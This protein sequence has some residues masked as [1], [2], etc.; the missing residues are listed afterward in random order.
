MRFALPYLLFCASFASA[1]APP[2]AHPD[3]LNQIAPALEQYVAKGELAGAV[4]V[5]GRSTGTLATVVVGNRTLDP[6]TP[7]TADTVF[8]IAS[9]TKP[10][11]ALAVMMLVENG[12]IGSIDDPVEKYLPEFRGQMLI[13]S[14]TKTRTTL[15]KPARAI[16][17]KDLLTHTSGLPG[18]YPPGIQDRWLTRTLTL[19]ETTIAIAQRPLEFAPGSKWSYCNPGIDTL[20]RVVEVVGGQGYE[21]F[22][23]A[24]L[25]KPLGMVDTTTRPT[26]EMLTRL[27]PVY[28]PVDGKLRRTPPGFLDARSDATHPTPCGGLVSTAA[29]LARLY[30][31]LL[32]GGELDGTRVIK[33]ETLALMTKTQT[34]DLTTGFTN[35]MSYGLGFAVVKTPA[36]VTAMLA[37][38]SFGHG[39]AF[40]TQSWADPKNDLFVILLIGRGHLP[41]SDDSVYRR[42]VQQL[43]ADAVQP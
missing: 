21:S 40:G 34:A 7:M 26:P 36:G 42:E 4:V 6:A 3:K 19:S 15:V 25:F 13:E 41:N 35:G 33:A 28:G 2:V 31:C 20:G 23:Q 38:G 29:D 16:T 1:Q 12:K 17:L 30:R 37:P 27:A 9:M 8:R 14:R 39:G 18:S 24:R 32:C 10:I 5:V 43:A 22:L 11:T